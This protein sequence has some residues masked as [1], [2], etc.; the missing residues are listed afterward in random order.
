MGDRYLKT[1]PEGKNAKKILTIVAGKGG[2]DEEEGKC[3]WM[4]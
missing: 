3:G 2:S 1:E 4:S